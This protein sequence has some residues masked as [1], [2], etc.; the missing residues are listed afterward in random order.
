M[1]RPN[2]QGMR[3]G[4]GAAHRKCER[5]RKSRSFFVSTLEKVAHILYNV[6]YKGA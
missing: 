1:P 6:F 4:K 3:K 5:L 2:W